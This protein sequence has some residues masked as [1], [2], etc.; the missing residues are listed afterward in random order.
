MKL[1]NLQQRTDAWKAWRRDGVTATDTPVILG[2]SSFKTPFRLWSEKTGRMSEPDLSVVPAVRWGVEHEAKARRMFE[3]QT[4]HVVTPACAE[5]DAMPVFRASF[6]GLTEAGEPV[7]IKCPQE[8]TLADVRAN[9]MKSKACTTY[10]WQVMHQ[11]FVS[12]ARRGWLVFLDGDHLIVFEIQR[13]E[14]DIKRLTQAG[15]TFFEKVALNEEPPRDPARDVFVPAGDEAVERWMQAARSWR[16]MQSRIDDLKAEIEQLKAAQEP[17]KQALV[18]QM[19]SFDA[20]DFGGV[21]VRCVHSQGAGSLARVLELLKERGT[22]PDAKDLERCREHGT[23]RVLVRATDRILPRDTVQQT[24][25]QL[26]ETAGQFS[27]GV[28]LVW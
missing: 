15:L 20:A 17:F 3:Q 24:N 2:V 7:E 16:R 27:E 5:H 10:Y 14:E 9:G 8:G 18:E 26:L 12:G 11:L 21:A 23:D 28:S 6:D 4:G 19:G 1:V 25:A 22:A 13:D